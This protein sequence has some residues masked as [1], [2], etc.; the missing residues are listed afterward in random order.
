M[1]YS[2]DFRDELRARC[3]NYAKKIVVYVWKQKM[4]DKI[5]LKLWSRNHFTIS[6]NY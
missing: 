4:W 3:A 5:P 2:F 1:H 6:G